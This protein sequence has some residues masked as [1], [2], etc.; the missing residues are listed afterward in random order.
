M[1]YL[2][3]LPFAAA[4]IKLSYPPKFTC[5]LS[6]IIEATV[7]VHL[8]VYS[9]KMACACVV[10]MIPSIIQVLSHISENDESTPRFCRELNA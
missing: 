3:S 5:Q 9:Q 8:I 4:V 1:I 6:I 2:L 7:T 10:R